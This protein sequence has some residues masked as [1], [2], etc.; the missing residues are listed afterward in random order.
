[1]LDKCAREGAAVR[2]GAAAGATLWSSRLTSEDQRL[3]NDGAHRD[4]V[5][6]RDD[7]SP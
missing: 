5:P 2:T 1:V 4:I 3:L 7:E 6:V